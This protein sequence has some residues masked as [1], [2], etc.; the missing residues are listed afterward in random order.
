MT[1]QLLETMFISALVLIF[2]DISLLEI[3]RLLLQMQ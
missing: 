3:N 2:L 1:H